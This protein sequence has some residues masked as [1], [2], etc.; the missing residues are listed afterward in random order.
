MKAVKVYLYIVQAALL[1]DY[2]LQVKYL[3]MITIIIS[4]CGDDHDLVTDF[5]SSSGDEDC[6]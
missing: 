1:I 2:L 3:E 6:P 4:E 5:L